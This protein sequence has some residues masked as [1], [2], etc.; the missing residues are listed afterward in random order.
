MAAQR[1]YRSSMVPEKLVLPVMCW[2]CFQTGSTFW[3]GNEGGELK[4][5]LISAGFHHAE[6]ND[7]KSKIAC[8]RCDAVQR[9]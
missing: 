2:K 3:E 7:G 8:D 1:G 9:D 5:V 6:P 4:L